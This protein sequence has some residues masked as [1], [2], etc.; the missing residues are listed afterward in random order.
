MSESVR[1]G[2][3]GNGSKLV[4]GGKRKITYVELRVETAPV[5]HMVWIIAS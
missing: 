4:E 3:R 1:K 2:K 5:E